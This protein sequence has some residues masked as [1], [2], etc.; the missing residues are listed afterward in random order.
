MLRPPPPDLQWL[1]RKNWGGNH[2]SK[3]LDHVMQLHGMDIYFSFLCPNFLCLLF[4]AF[5][6][7]SDPRFHEPVFHH[8]FCWKNPPLRCRNGMF[9]PFSFTDFFLTPHRTQTC[10]GDWEPGAGL[11]GGPAWR[12]LTCP[13]AEAPGCRRALRAAPGQPFWA[14][15]GGPRLPGDLLGG[16]P[17]PPA[18]PLPPP[19]AGQPRPPPLRPQPRPGR[20]GP[21]R[22][23]S[24]PL[25]GWGPRV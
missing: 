17:G 16:V 10:P 18:E 9:A 6:K 2:L 5:F 19:V 11:G 1:L 8:Q 13:S 20:G 23:V 3:F 21:R 14:G 22:A 25:P 4:F 15:P 12:R 24:P 7:K